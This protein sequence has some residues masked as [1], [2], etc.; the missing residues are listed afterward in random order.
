MFLLLTVSGE[1]NSL[2][3]VVIMKRELAEIKAHKSPNKK[4]V[5]IYKVGHN[6]IFLSSNFKFSYALFKCYL[7]RYKS[8]LH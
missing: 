7:T 3:Q 4:E 8:M 1:Q 6:Y 5:C 2:E